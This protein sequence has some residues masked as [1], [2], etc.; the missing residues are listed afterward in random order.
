VATVK[1][2]RSIVETCIAG[3]ATLAVLLSG[4]RTPAAAATHPGGPVPR[5]VHD[6]TAQLD[7]EAPAVRAAAA[8]G[9]GFLRA[10]SAEAALIGRLEDSSSEVRRQAAMALAW[11]GGRRAVEPL[12]DALG[13][14]DWIVRQAAHVSLTNLTGMEF[15]FTSTAEEAKRSAE[16]RRWRDWWAGVTPTRP[17]KE[18]LALLHGPKG[19]I[20]G[21]PVYTSS[22][23][24]GPAEI[25][26]DGRLGPEYWQTKQVPFP[27]WCTV[28]LGK[29][30]DVASVVVHQ[31]GPGFVMTEYAVSTSLDNRQFDEVVRRKGAT[32]VKLVVNFPKRKA[33]YVRITSFGSQNPTYPT[34]FFEIEIDG[35]RAPVRRDPVEWR[36][37]RGLRA[38]GTL[39]GEGATEAILE[40]LGPVPSNAA[41]YR[42]TVRAGIRALGRLRDEA[43]FEAL[44]A[45]LD[46]PM[47]A[48]HAAE[49]LGD[50]G[51]RRAVPALLAAYPRYAKNLAGANPKDVPG[52]D[53]MGFP[54]E[55]RM[56]HTPYA[57]IYA[58]S[59][60]PLDAPA[61]RAALRE[62]A[63]L[64]MANLPGDHDT[65]FLYQPEVGHVLTQYLIELTGLRQ[66]A[67]EHAL[68]SLG[69][70]G[71]AARP[72]DALVWSTFPAYRISSWL[73]C[74]CTEKQDL[75]RLL[76]LLGHKEGWV[77]LNAA[78]AIAW[79][80]DERAIDPL[81][82]LLAEAKPEADFG[83]N[84]TFK[85]EEYDDMAPR[86]R[87][88]L[89]RALGLL[90]AHQHTD[91][92]VSVLNDERSVLEVR[93]A[94]AEALSDLGN[95]RA[96]AALRTAAVSHSFRSV[97]HVARDGMR[98]HGGRI[99]TSGP[100][101]SGNA[102][103]AG[104]S[105]SAFR[106]S[107]TPALPEAI[108]FI[109]GSNNIPNTIG[110]VEQADR[111]RQTYV[112]TDSGPAYRPGRNLCVLRPPRPDGKVTPLTRFADGYVGEPE[113]S[114]DGS[115]V[116][117]CR[118]GQ[119]DPWWH[120]FRINVDGSGLR[121][122]TFGPYHD[123]GPAY[124]PDGRIV[125]A[126]SRLGIRDEYHGYPCTGL[127]V[128]NPD[129]SD[130]H[131]IATNIGRDN[132]PAVL[133][134]GRIV[135]SRLE[136]FYSR[137]K[138]ELTLHAAHPDGTQDVVLYGPE[139]RPYWRSL[140]HGP[141]TP[142]DG[143]E[144]PLT[145][146][147]LRM[148][149]PQPMPDGR[150]VVVVTQGGLVLVGQ[151]RD[152]EETITPDNHTRSYTTPFPLADGTILCASTLKTPDRKQ[153]DLGLYRFDPA[154][155]ELDLIYNDPALADFEPR[156]ILARSRPML[157][158]P[159]AQRH[160]Y[161]GRFVCTSVYATQEEEV[162]VRGRFVRLIEGVPK[163]ARHS[164]HTNPWE[165]WKNHGG[166]FARVLGTAPLAPDGSFYVEAPADRL[167]HFQ[168]LDS[169]RRVVGQQLTWIYPRGG[170][171]KS[172]VG[173]H[174]DPHTT[175]RGNDPLASHY[176]P[177]DFLPDGREFT[178]RAKAW[179]KGSLPSE[180]EERT[181]T[182]RAVNL[183]GRQ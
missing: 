89:L 129:G 131:P 14:H 88:G 134:D 71:R 21:G 87:E 138:T 73:P 105:S 123:V 135:F 66:D 67:C 45:L 19:G 24:R 165:V 127:N 146:R 60:L 16:A 122:L 31:Y 84:A 109:Q 77:R 106:M 17:P 32:P 155:K 9:L 121:Q 161:S 48:R 56:L 44:V 176:P 104:H 36:Q 99:A 169:D 145:H 148:T 178:Y 183:L 42:P 72:D 179:F 150:H 120:L 94:A 92:I 78:K 51:D 102:A 61:D 154:T 35:H 40:V 1:R 103:L 139:R 112:V 12:L 124:L 158:A 76:A 174:E 126:S 81:A 57:I 132:E 107:P 163:V 37:E 62:L 130:I 68:T 18:V 55:D 133:N 125:F 113:L 157:Q 128:M 164:T 180:I 38:L 29:V 172:C 160:A 86:W 28:D 147:V 33:R 101:G 142:A 171:V 168:V 156:P 13:D 30:R 41:N 181:R 140:D 46:N 175:T 136:V 159:K 96:L 25:L 4:M 70:P 91:L 144:A 6:K 59:R 177:V 52:D 64:L 83:Y 93:Y 100:S 27:Q 108:V 49:A 69:Q 162:A 7:D 170:E 39:G 173:C 115:H 118:R 116:I 149:Q 153:V 90:G 53:R 50:F 110:T 26:L 114:F 11:C 2:T 85:N 75:P 152:T 80:G 54:S 95:P 151:R 22:T 182:V 15:P 97:R 137:N 23:Y 74:V 63:P 8:E 5:Q 119:D 58:L 10:Y 143:Q 82:K 111:W 34:T 3:I 117:F 43:G 65:F 79:L 47:W 20:G 167:L 98:K 141:R 166:T